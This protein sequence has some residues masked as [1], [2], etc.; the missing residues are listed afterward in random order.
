LNILCRRC[1]VHDRRYLALI[2]GFRTRRGGL[3]RH[4]GGL[5][6]FAF[7]VVNS[8]RLSEGCNSGRIGPSGRRRD[9]RCWVNGEGFEHL[10]L[11]DHL[12]VDRIELAAATPHQA[13]ASG[14]DDREQHASVQHKCGGKAKDL[15]SPKSGTGRRRRY[16]Q[17]LQHS[18]G[19]CQ[20]CSIR[21]AGACSRYRFAWS[22]FCLIH[23][24][25]GNRLERRKSGARRR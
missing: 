7:L 3:V 4:Q 18:D 13:I 5:G 9:P 19:V 17:G 6:L 16:R 14:V 23:A 10:R 24:C 11:R 2:G 20:G 21:R 22:L 25:R 8:T 12:D 15:A 1:G